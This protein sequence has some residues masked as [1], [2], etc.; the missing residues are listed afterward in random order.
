MRKRLY[1]L[2]TVGFL[3]SFIL[4]ACGTTPSSSTSTPTKKGP[5]T[6][7]YDVYWLGNSWSVQMY[8]EFKQAVAQHQTDIKDVVYTQSDDQV[9]KQ[10]ANIQSMIAR[11]VDA[12]I[13]TPVSPAAVVPVIEQ[14]KQAG[15]PVI[16]LAATANT[17]DYTALVTVD[18]VQFGQ[19][20][21]TWLAKKLNGQGNIYVLN[22]IAG[23]S[24]NSDRW[25]GAESVFSHYPGIKVIAS[26]NANWDEATA[27]TAVTNMLA[28][29]PNVDGIWSQGGA[30]TLGA[31]EAFEAA[32]H[33]LVP[34]TGEDYNGLLK[35]WQELHNSGDTHFDSIAV[36]K[37]TWLSAPA[38]D[39]T[40]KILKGQPYQKNDIIPPP[41]I[42]YAD[43]NKY[44][45]PDLPD[46]YWANSHLSAAVVK[47]LF[48]H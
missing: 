42:T 33:P 31:I 37:P 46:S 16:L 3:L 5:F 35:K 23:L 44:V 21:A 30:M 38:L 34:M 48:S 43:L 7:G 29:H 19:V 47:Q 4:I 12:I 28:A 1:V 10:I 6:I 27:K 22:G 8:Q 13:M 40:L 17:E 2:F 26:Q 20:Q 18:D 32:G 41:V 36:A 15:I 39:V 24:T 11:K 9:Q 14:A 45:R 25:N